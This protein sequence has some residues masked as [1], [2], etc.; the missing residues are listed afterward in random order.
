MNIFIANIIDDTAFIEAEESWHC[1]KVLSKKAGDRIAIIDG[2]GFYA[3]GVLELVSE[4]KCKVQLMGTPQL[5]T[6]K[7][8]PIAFGYCAH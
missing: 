2:K 7:N 4:K 8:L 3:E 5:Q 6:K 1:C